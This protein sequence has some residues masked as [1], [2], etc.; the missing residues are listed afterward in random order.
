LFFTVTDHAIV[1]R[2][3]PLQPLDIKQFKEIFTTHAERNQVKLFKLT[4][5]PL[6]NMLNY[7]FNRYFD[8]T[9]KLV[10]ATNELQFKV[11]FRL[12]NNGFGSYLNTY[13][14]LKHHYKYL[15]TLHSLQIGRIIIADEFSQLLFKF[16]SNQIPTSG[17]YQTLKLNLKR[18]TIEPNAVTLRYYSKLSANNSSDLYA[19]RF[20][21]QKIIQII[22]AHDPAWRLSLAQLLQPLFEIAYQRSTL[23]TAIAENKKVIIV[24][25]GYVNQPD[26]QRYFPFNN[27]DG[28]QIQYATYLYK[29]M[30]MAKHFMTSAL[31]TAVGNHTLAL[32]LGQKKE[33][34]DAKIGSGFSF[35]D[36]AGD[37]AGIR[38]G[39][40]ATNSK[41]NARRLQKLMATIKDYRAFMPE[42]RDLP[43]NI[44]D[45]AFKNQFKS[46]NSPAYQIMLEKIDQRITAL[47][48]YQSSP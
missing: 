12:P 22:E 38:F 27:T 29:R 4:Q 42:V 43:E 47:P 23:D 44:S 35:I 32:I 14:T 31:L 7:F 46:T 21:Q 6:N 30:D 36:L 10:L 40:M 13:F 26:I 39:K 20:Y 25:S 17:F 2:S 48:L 34:R 41:T 33:L 5:K 24:V 11:T 37:Q 19:L 28:S 16:L 1:S 18:L 15:F 45:Q 3:Y 9:T 8:V